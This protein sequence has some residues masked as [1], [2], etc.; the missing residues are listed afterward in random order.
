M[1][2]CSGGGSH[3]CPTISAVVRLRLNPCCAVEQKEQSKA[4]PTCEE[5]HNVPR[6]GSGMNTISNAWEESARNTHLQVSSADL[7]RLTISGARIAARSASCA[8]KSF[9]RS[10]MF[11]NEPSP[12]L[13]NQFM[14]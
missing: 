13:Y 14:S 1:A 12:R 6:S 11:S 8:R 4:H 2:A 5:M 7:C 9:A 10:V 3:T